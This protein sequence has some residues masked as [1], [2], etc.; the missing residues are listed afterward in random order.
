[1]IARITG[2][3]RGVP[4]LTQDRD[5]KFSEMGREQF[6]GAAL[7]EEE[8]VREPRVEKGQ[9]EPVSQDRVVRGRYRH[10]FR[11]PAVGN[12]AHRELLKRSRVDGQRLG[13]RRPFGSPFQHNRP[14]PAP[15]QLGSQPHAHRAAADHDHI[16]RSQ[17][18]FLHAERFWHQFDG[19]K[20]RSATGL[21]VA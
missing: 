3:V 16:V 8:R 7:R 4:V 18:L 13:M 19:T 15:V 12:P 17:F 11:D 2:V 21:L 14:N 5:A 9:I 20:P 6:L 1:V 10:A